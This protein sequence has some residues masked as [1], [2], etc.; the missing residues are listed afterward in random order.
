M[1]IYPSG[2][3]KFEVNPIYNKNNLILLIMHTY[4]LEIDIH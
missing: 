1:T 3:N 2:V 4:T